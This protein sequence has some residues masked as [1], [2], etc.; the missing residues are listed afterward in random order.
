MPA[1]RPSKY[2]EEVLTLSQEYVDG[3]Y[4]EDDQVIPTVAG[5]A[6]HI[7]VSRETVYDWAKQEDKAKFSD[8]VGDLMAKQ[9]VKLLNSGL[10]GEFNPNIAKLA[11]T[12]HGYV[13]K[14]DINANVKVDETTEEQVDAAIERKLREYQ[15][16]T[17]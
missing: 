5:L 6:I 17:D 15:V 11:L 13:D 1:G 3:D 7:G 8:I 9:E 4:K 14:Q 10:K 2:S 16:I 12:K